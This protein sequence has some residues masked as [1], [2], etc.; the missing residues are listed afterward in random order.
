[1]TSTYKPRLL[2]LAAYDN[3]ILR[4]KTKPVS[5]PL[6]EDDKQTIADMI[7]SI[8]PEQLL[9]AG[10]P[11]ENAVGMAANQWGIDKSIFVYCPTGDTVNDL[12]VAINPSYE[13]VP[14]L[15]I[16]APSET[17]EWEGCFSIPLSTGCIKRSTKIKIKYQNEE[18][19]V[20]ED[21]LKDWPARVWQHE[22]DHLNGYLYDDPRHGKCLE[23]KVFATIDEV[24][25]FYDAIREARRAT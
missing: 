4:N 2:K 21:E 18:G 5:F 11:W 22:N 10:A 3:P 15:A 16:I 19:T 24:D 13:I 1:M 6:S 14:T 8:Q 7:Y 9:T 20:I 17:S 23:K 12:T 25:E